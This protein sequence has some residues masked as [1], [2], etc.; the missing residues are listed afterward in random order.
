MVSK[1]DR[2]DYE[3]GRRDSKK[4][5]WDQFVNDMGGNHPG[6]DAYYKGRRGEQLDKDQKKR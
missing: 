5:T 4:G 1:K 3:A 6:T 2:D